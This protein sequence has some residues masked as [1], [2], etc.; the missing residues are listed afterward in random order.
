VEWDGKGILCMNTVQTVSCISQPEIMLLW[1]GDWRYNSALDWSTCLVGP[2]LGTDAWAEFCLS[3]FWLIYSISEPINYWCWRVLIF[4]LKRFEAKHRHWF[5]ALCLDTASWWGGLDWLG[6]RCG[7]L[8]EDMQHV[9]PCKLQCGVC[10]KRCRYDNLSTQQS[11][12][13]VTFVLR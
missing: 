8:T 13:F 1:N 12:G 2:R 9:R 6:V 10:A 4:G 7:R 5:E 3:I 11:W